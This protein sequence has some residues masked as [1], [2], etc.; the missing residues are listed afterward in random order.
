MIFKERYS[1]DFTFIGKD[2][3]SGHPGFL[4]GRNASGVSVVKVLLF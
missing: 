3:F 1:C 4:S 2:G